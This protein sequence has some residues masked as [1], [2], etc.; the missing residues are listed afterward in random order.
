M[1]IAG[2]I[3]GGIARRRDT[4]PEGR[5]RDG[6]GEPRFQ[7][8]DPRL[9]NYLFIATLV[10]VTLG[11]C[12]SIFTNTVGTETILRD[13]RHFKLDAERNLGA[14]FESMLLAASGICGLL[15]GRVS[16]RRGSAAIAQWHVI[17]IVFLGLSLDETAGFHEVVDVPIREYFGLTGLAYNPWVFLAGLFVAGFALFMLPLLDALPRRTA[18]LF[19][20][21]GAVFVGGAAGMEPLD[22]WAEYAHGEDSVQQIFFT[23]IEEALEMTGICLFLYALLDHMKRQR[24]SVHFL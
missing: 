21:A 5:R 14:W 19:V 4:G 23:T 7:I 1:A 15:M 20:V 22:A 12:Q 2:T 9:A 13:L 16:K 6:A 18:F 11:I 10:I 24:I 8:I 3:T 17:G